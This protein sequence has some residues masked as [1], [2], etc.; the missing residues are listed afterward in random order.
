MRALL[1][2]IAFLGGLWAGTEVWRWSLSDMTGQTAGSIEHLADRGGDYDIVVI[3]SSLTRVNFLPAEFDAAMAELGHPVTSFGLGIKG[4]RGAEIHYYVDKVL[5][6]HLPKL[7]LIL[8]DV[9]LDQEMLIDTDGGYQRRIIEWHDWPRFLLS[10]RQ[11]ISQVPTWTE[12]WPYL[13]A[14]VRHLLLNRL[15]IGF[16]IEALSSGVWFDG[17]APIKSRTLLVTGRSIARNQRWKVDKYLKNR[18]RHEAARDQLAEKRLRPPDRPRSALFEREL[19]DLARRH[20]VQLAFILSPVLSDARFETQV[21]NDTPLEVLDFD[22]PA[23]YPELY[24][25]DKRYD[26]MHLS[27]GGSLAFT[28]A[29][30]QQVTLHFYDEGKPATASATH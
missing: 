21:K 8:A 10:V 29:L 1:G 28:R 5:Q 7:K 26:P 16:G 19:R 2:L 24:E 11:V 3:G 23:H 17:P 20:H 12:R 9:S 30:A 13:D 14:H 4:M 25:P 6:M 18:T 27:Y 15:N 22:D